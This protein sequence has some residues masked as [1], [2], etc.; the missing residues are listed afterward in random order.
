MPMETDHSA[1]EAWEA[2]HWDQLQQVFHQVE[3]AVPEERESTLNAATDDPRVRSRVLKLLQ[4]AG[5]EAGGPLLLRHMAHAGIRIGPYSVEKHLGTGGLGS[6]YLCK[7]TVAGTVQ[8]CA[9]KVLSK[10]ATGPAFLARF[11]REQQI[12]ASLNHTGIARLLDADTT[13]TGES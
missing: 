11:R 1:A 7:R 3:A 2:E 4:A 13:D 5:G 8:Q 12:L 10:H 6:V 9:V